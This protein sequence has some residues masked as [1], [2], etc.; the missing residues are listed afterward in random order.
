[1]KPANWQPM[2]T[3]PRDGRW[4]TAWS[5]RNGLTCVKWKRGWYTEDG[6]RVTDATEWTPV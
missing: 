4:I 5:R 1:M 3:A 6:Q 2:G